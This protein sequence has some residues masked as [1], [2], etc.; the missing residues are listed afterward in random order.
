MTDGPAPRVS[1]VV[2]CSDGDAAA[3]GETLLSLAAQ[4]SSDFE[5]RV[6]VNESGA[7]V[8]AVTEQIE[9]F[10]ES[11]AN[12]V[13]LSAWDTTE[14]GTP[15][16]FGVAQ[17]RADYVAPVYPDDVVFA[18][19]IE[20][21]GRHAPS[22]DGRAMSSLVARQAVEVAPW[23][24]GRRVTTLRRPR[25]ADQA[26]FNL[27]AHLGSP[28]ARLGGLALPRRAL[29][30]IATREIPPDA[31]D[32]AIRLA[33]ALSCGVFETGDVT[34]LDRTSP[35]VGPAPFDADAWERHRVSALGI[36]DTCGLALGTGVL[37]SLGDQAAGSPRPEDLDRLRELLREAEARG[38]A[39][40]AGE[41]AALGRVED[42]LR[43]ASWKVTAPLRALGEA[44]RQRGRGSGRT[45]RL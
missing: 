5:V 13:H 6:V 18:H 9:S 34:Y 40:A 26:G 41:A 17:S 7:A 25:V 2:I 35:T 15:F 24:D 22:A 30:G 33:V 28:P 39:H 32:W 27:F 11:F 14:S 12:R 3:V 1:V 21:F 42:L 10:D 45:P 19:Y 4:T 8:A 37:Q 29:P 23:G 36:L 38:R 31:R 20:S 44:A 43:S 16:E